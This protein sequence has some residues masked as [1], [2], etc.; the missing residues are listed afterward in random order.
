MHNE[1]E[2]LNKKIECVKAGK[3]F[4]NSFDSKREAIATL[5]QLKKHSSESDTDNFIIISE[6]HK[7]ILNNA[8]EQFLN[9]FVLYTPSIRNAVDVSFEHKQPVFVDHKGHTIN[10]TA[11]YQQ[12][13]RTRNPEAI[14]FNSEVKMNKCKFNTFDDC[15]KYYRENNRISNNLNSV[16]SYNDEDDEEKLI[17]NTYFKLFTYNEYLLHIFHSNRLNPSL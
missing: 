14:Y 16:C 3:Y 1:Y 10:P 5:E 12:T 6:D 15:Q 2:H 4:L 13:T 17:E 9:K 8:S 7:T 11:I